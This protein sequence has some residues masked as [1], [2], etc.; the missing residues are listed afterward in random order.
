MQTAILIS[1]N[2]LNEHIIEL[3]L[4]TQ[5]LNTLAGQR[6]FI[7]FLE[8]ET[9]LKRAYSIADVYE[10]GEFS[11]FTFLI[12][13]LPWGKG[14]EILRNADKNTQFWLEWPNGHFILRNTE[15][16]KVFLST[17]SGLAPCY[18][19]AKEDRSWAKKR[20]FFS[21]SYEKDLFYTDEIRALKIPQTHISISREEVED[22]EFWRINL[23]NYIFP[24]ETEFYICGVPLMVKE[25]LTELRAKGFT[26][27]F[28]EAY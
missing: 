28:V 20:F 6:L 9:P 16:P 13:L 3:K 17:G 24:T 5:K 19:M 1:K 23:D 27:I 12:K 2:F 25:F 18:H 11:I 14:S 7:H 8:S 21:V 4:K 10:E 22:F 15:Y 26:N